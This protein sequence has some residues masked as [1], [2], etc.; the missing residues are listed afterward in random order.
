MKENVVDVLMFLFDNYLGLEAAVEISEE[1]LSAELEEA[2]FEINDIN[3][4][5]DWLGDL[6]DVGKNSHS[7]LS[8]PSSTIRIFNPQ[9]QKKLDASCQG[10]L[11]ELIQKGVL[12]IKTRELIIERAMAIEG[13]KLPFYCFKK[14]A[15]LIMMNRNEAKEIQVWLKELLFEDEEV[16]H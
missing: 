14:I 4:A 7:W 1:S 5:F 10:F 2:G 6:T 13:K 3:R 12:D 8:L 15:V 16:L 9:E 11:H